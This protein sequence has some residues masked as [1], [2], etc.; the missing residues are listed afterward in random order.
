MEH[1]L[2]SLKSLQSNLDLVE[3]SIQDQQSKLTNVESLVNNLYS[4]TRIEDFVPNN[5]YKIIVVKQEGRVVVLLRLDFVP[6]ENSI[7]AI[8]STQ[9]GQF[10]LLAGLNQYDNLVKE[11]FASGTEINSIQ[12]KYIKRNDINPPVKTIFWVSTNKISIGG[13]EVYAEHL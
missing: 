7:Q 13:S 8:A 12:V 10:P 11:Y 2:I 6:V 3:I 4:K 5:T 1:Q 9:L